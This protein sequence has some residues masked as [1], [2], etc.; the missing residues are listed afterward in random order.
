[1]MR[2]ILS[3]VAA[4]LAAGGAA[5]A[6]DSREG[7]SGS[8]RATA[9]WGPC[10]IPVPSA[11][12]RRARATRSPA[13]ARTCGPPRTPSTSS[14]RRRPATSSLAADISF[15]GAGND[16]HR[17]A[18]LMIRQSLDADSAYVDVA[19]HGDG[20]TS[21]QFREAKGA[22][23]HE[24]QANVSAPGRLRLEKRGKYATAVPGGRR[25]RSRGSPGAAVRIAFEEP[26]Y[27][28]IGVCSHN[29]DVTEKAVFSNVE[30]TTPVAGLDR[31]AGRSTAR[32]KRRRSPRPTAASSTSRPAGSRPPT[33]C[34]TARR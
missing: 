7:G 9:T 22:A 12:T 11:S 31:P 29:K 16:P 25:A 30:L 20:L 8:S 27:V 4:L 34:A 10:S 2:S 3:L 21:L 23:T 5:S 18:C 15:L 1:M 17:K 32:S 28:G 6:T 19:L 24:V 26:F 33:G 14:G 13:A